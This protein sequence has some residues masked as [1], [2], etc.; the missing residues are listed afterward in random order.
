MQNR[1]TQFNTL[2]LPEEVEKV[3]KN[4]KKDL[5]QMSVLQ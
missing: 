3:I 5:Q 1:N 2:G 4:E